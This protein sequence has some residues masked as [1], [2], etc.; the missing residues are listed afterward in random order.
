M[1]TT[2]PGLTARGIRLGGDATRSTKRI[3]SWSLAL[4]I[5]AFFGAVPTLVLLVMI[6]RRTTTA[7]GAVVAV[8]ACCAVLFSLVAIVRILQM[9]LRFGS[10]K[11]PMT[12]VS[13]VGPL[14]SLGAAMAWLALLSFIGLAFILGALAINANAPEALSTIGRS[15]EEI[16]VER[17]REIVA[18]LD[19]YARVHQRFPETDDYARLPA[20]LGRAEG[21]DAL[22]ELDGWSQPFEYSSTNHNASGS[23]YTLLSLGG[24]GIK[25][26]PSEVYSR[27]GG[28]KTPAEFAGRDFRVESGVFVLGPEN[29]LGIV[30]RPEVE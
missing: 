28:K 6:A 3:R 15:K 20:M 21:Q 19:A 8:A 5:V 25:Q 9:S 27:R 14:E 22:A 12:P 18:A 26:N 7:T 11:T 1:T 17:M 24:D 29:V 4:A 30:L 23:A 2:Q 13:L 10:L 16:T